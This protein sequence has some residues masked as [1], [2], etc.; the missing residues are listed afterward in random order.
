MIQTN[1]VASDTPLSHLEQKCAPS[2]NSGGS[3]DSIFTTETKSQAI[4]RKL[5]KNGDCGSQEDKVM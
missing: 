2:A 4:G 1:D 5:D 3:S